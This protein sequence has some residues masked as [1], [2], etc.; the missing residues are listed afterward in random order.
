M[1]QPAEEDQPR[2][3]AGELIG[4]SKRTEGDKQP[5]PKRGLLSILDGVNKSVLSSG[6]HV[7]EFLHL[8]PDLL[9][10]WLV[11][12]IDLIALTPID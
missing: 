11:V 8:F 12:I 10:R 9:F 1:S 2:Q 3:P 5:S 7:V 6:S 4:R